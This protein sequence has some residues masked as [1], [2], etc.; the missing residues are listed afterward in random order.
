M[1]ENKCPNAS[2]DPKIQTQFIDEKLAA[3]QPDAAFYA[4]CTRGWTGP[5]RSSYGAA[6]SD[7]RAHENSTGH[8]T[9]VL[10]RR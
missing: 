4:A 7:A 10:S 3:E 8:H 2:D 6:Q 1:S 9:G 5:T